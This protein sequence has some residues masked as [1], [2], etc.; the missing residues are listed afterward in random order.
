MRGITPDLTIDGGPEWMP[1]TD[2]VSGATLDEFL[3]TAKQ[4]WRATPH[5]AAALAWKCYSYWL[6]LPAVLGYAA[7]RRVPLLR[8]E[9]VRW[10]WSPRQPFLVVGLSRVEVAVLPSDPLAAGTP[11]ARL[12]SGVRVVAD[13]RELL[14]ELRDSLMDQHLTPLLEQLR[15]G[16]HVS[17][18]TFWGSLA[19]GVAHGVSRAADVVPG[20]SLETAEAVLGA[21]GVGELVELR[22][23]DGGRAGVQ[24]RR[25]T[26]CLAFTL[27]E[28]KVCAGCCIR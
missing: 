4:R 7:A 1:A 18:R 8:P 9:A 19:S 21:L 13:E 3:D 26:C 16:V 22:P 25:R 24:V 15:R 27:P 6:S 20:S 2:L 10:Q 14:A 11:Q 5:A 23:R 12:A 17:A 28:P